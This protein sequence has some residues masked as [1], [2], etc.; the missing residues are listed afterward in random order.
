MILDGHISWSSDL[1]RLFFKNILK[2]ENVNEG[3]I[4][5][6]YGH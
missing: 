1:F 6:E 5:D 4:E 3:V 2:M